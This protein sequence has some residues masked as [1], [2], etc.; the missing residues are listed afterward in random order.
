[1]NK[2]LD[3]GKYDSRVVD[4]LKTRFSEVADF[5]RNRMEP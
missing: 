4:Y 1:M 3:E 2:A 5:M